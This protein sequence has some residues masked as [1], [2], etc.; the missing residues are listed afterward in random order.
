MAN[1]GDRNDFSVAASQSAQANFEQVASQ[2]EAALARRDADV[3]AAMAAYQA[4]GV[5]DRYA[6]MEAAWNQAGQEVRAIIHT[7]RDA[8]SS[9]DEIAGRALRQAAAAIPD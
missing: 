5:S 1:L 3:K 4:D 9:N 6:S 7:I 2:L 8:L